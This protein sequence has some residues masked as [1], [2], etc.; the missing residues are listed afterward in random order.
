MR[1]KIPKKIT[2]QDQNVQSETSSRAS[3]PE[4]T[5]DAPFPCP[6]PPKKLRQTSLSGFFFS[7]SD[8]TIFH[9]TQQHNLIVMEVQSLSG[10]RFSI[11]LHCTCSASMI[12]C[13]CIPVAYMCIFHVYIMFI[14]HGEVPRYFMLVFISSYRTFC[15]LYPLPL[16]FIF[17]FFILR[18]VQ[19]MDDRSISQS[20]LLTCFS[21]PILLQFD[22]NL[23]SAINC[24][25]FGYYRPL[26]RDFWTIRYSLVQTFV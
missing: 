20:D 10:L 13:R 1:M 25:P 23:A 5:D 2:R 16:H 15:R 8:Y 14:F 24:F 26:D 12:M 17:T 11:N 19:L 9:S 22:S 4:I 7:R 21:M 6:P 18:P 3:S